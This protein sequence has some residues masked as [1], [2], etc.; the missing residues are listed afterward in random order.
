MRFCI[1]I[2]CAFALFGCAS[3]TPSQTIVENT[4]REVAAVQETVKKIELQTPKECKTELFLANLE[5]VNRQV[6]T[7]GG[8]IESIG[9]SCQTEKQV[10]EERIVARNMAIVCLLLIGVGLFFLL[11]KRKWSQEDVDEI[12]E[13]VDAIPSTYLNKKTGGDISGA[14]RFNA[15]VD[16]NNTVS[17]FKNVT[18][19][20]EVTFRNTGTTILG[21][22]T[23]TVEPTADNMPATKKYVDNQVTQ[24]ET[25]I[26][27][28][29]T[30]ITTLRK[31]LDGLGD[32][33]SDIQATVNTLSSKDRWILNG[34]PENLTLTTSLQKVVMP[35]TTRFPTTQPASMEMT[36]DGTGILFKKAGL[37]H[38]SRRV[39]LGG[40]NTENL[41]YQMRVNDTQLEPLQ[42]QAVSVSKNTMSY[43]LDFYWQVT[44]QQTLSIW[45]NCLENTCALNY[46]G[47][48]TIIEYI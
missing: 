27:T 13:T 4:R 42:T 38:F 1:V 6:S 21:T 43:T 29:A 46:K 10:L 37:I 18:L 48:T 3:K 5:A 9:L 23:I 45:A 41:Y 26:A 15:H 31:D 25:A 22:T 36:E 39:S 40:S 28:N 8:Q 30:N 11:I 2:L 34:K 12:K 7:I 14:S 32:Q 33:V 35:A 17:H 16:F 44:A 19:G 24:V 47:V 20:S